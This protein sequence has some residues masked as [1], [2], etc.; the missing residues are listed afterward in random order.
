MQQGKAVAQLADAAVALECYLANEDPALLPLAV[1]KNLVRD[2]GTA[3]GT[4]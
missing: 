4:G 2:V 3:A 1:Y